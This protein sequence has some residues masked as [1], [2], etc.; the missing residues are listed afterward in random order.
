MSGSSRVRLV[1]RSDEQLVDAYRSAGDRHALDELVR[2]YSPLL[3]RLLISMLRGNDEAILDAEQEV[4]ATMV[5]KL[6]SFGGRSKFSTFF[7]RLARNRTIDLIRSTTRQR[8]RERPEPEF[9]VHPA[10]TPGPAEELIASDRVRAVRSALDLL[11]PEDRY[12][13]Y[14]HEAEGVPLATLSKSLGIPVGTAKSRIH[15]LRKRLAEQLEGVA[16][17]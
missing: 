7:Y 10:Q 17:E 15:R 12:L 14:M 16:R 2:R 9:D 8:R 6:N 5:R 1:D 4:F 11:A 3:R 13:V